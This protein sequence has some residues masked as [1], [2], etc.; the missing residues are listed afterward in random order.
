M[1][2]KPV[3]I[4]STENR[5]SVNG[6]GTVNQFTSNGQETVQ[7]NLCT[8]SEDMTSF[9]DT[10]EKNLV[11]KLTEH[12]IKFFNDNKLMLC[13]SS[14]S[15]PRINLITPDSGGNSVGSIFQIDLLKINGEK[16][17]FLSIGRDDDPG[18]GTVCMFW[19]VCPRWNSTQQFEN[20]VKKGICE[21]IY[22]G[23]YVLR[24]RAKLRKV[25]NK[26]GNNDSPEL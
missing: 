5:T 7:V 15:G 4:F 8:T 26:L 22:D 9:E 2:I 21:L 25:Y 13:K 10:D 12:A 11:D 16:R 1:Q 17:L 14:V 20:T 6:I 19:I 23:S 24:E 18:T 3:G